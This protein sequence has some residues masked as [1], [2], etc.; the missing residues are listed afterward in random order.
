MSRYTDKHKDLREDQK[1]AIAPRAREMVGPSYDLA[2][3]LIESANVRVTCSLASDGIIWGRYKEDDAAVM[4]LLFNAFEPE[5]YRLKHFQLDL[6]LGTTEASDGSIPQVYVLHESQPEQLPGVAPRYIEGRPLTVQQGRG[7]TVGPKL[8]AGFGGGELGS[9]SRTSEKSVA[10]RWI[11]QGKAVSDSKT[12]VM[13]KASWSW[14]ANKV[15]PQVDDIGDLHGGLALRHGGAPLRLVCDVE[16]KL[17]RGYRRFCFGRSLKAKQKV[18][19][20]PAEL[21]SDC[22]EDYVKN[23]GSLMID[24]NTRPVARKSSIMSCAFDR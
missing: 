13:T 24:R 20:R 17:S 4:H 11:F 9:W 21:S 5:G 16:G 14:E 18:W 1:I 22:I 3:P 6:G 23:L 8:E 10:Y 15:N 7:F 12:G 2:A 19:E